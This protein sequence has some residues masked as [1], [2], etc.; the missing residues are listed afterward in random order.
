M[1]DNR[2]KEKVIEELTRT[3]TRV[4]DIH[5]EVKRLKDLPE[6]V[7]LVEKDNDYLHQNLTQLGVKLD[8]H[9]QEDTK[10][11]KALR[12]AILVLGA[13]MLV[14]LVGTFGPEQIITWLTKVF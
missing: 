13:I 3:S 14:V 4:Q 10:A 11:F 2:F 7:S 9:V 6:R 1:D 12:N 5:S 8:S